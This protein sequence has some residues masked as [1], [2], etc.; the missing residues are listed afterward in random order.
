MRQRLLVSVAAVLV[1]LVVLAT[2]VGNP[3][4]AASVGPPVA[5][6][7][8]AGT[9]SSATPTT[10]A[11]GTGTGTWSP[12]TPSPTPV[13]PRTHTPGPDGYDWKTVTVHDRADGTTLATVDVRLA[14]TFQKRYTGLSDT[15]SLGPNEGML[16]VHPSEGNHTYVMRRMSF[17]LDIVFLNASGNVTRIHHAP[18]PS[19]TPGDDLVGYG[20]YGK[21]VLEVPMNYTTDRGIEAGDYVRIRDVDLNGTPPGA[22]CPCDPVP[23][24]QTT[25]PPGAAAR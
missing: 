20:G 9:G 14:D 18:L 2:V 23:V 5:S 19:E 11:A 21:Y 16:F 22:V 13:P 25:A 17:P 6:H 1:V 24:G 8:G 15:G 3:F 10:A 12:A 7:D 4:A